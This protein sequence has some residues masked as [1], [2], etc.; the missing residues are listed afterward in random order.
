MKG[1]IFTPYEAT[2]TLPL[3]KNIVSDITN[4]AQRLRKLALT[5]P[6]T[7]ES[8]DEMSVLELELQEHMDELKNLGC[9]YKDW[10]FEIGLVDF[11]GIID[12]QLVLLCWRSDEPALE[13][14]HLPQAG[15]SG[16]KRIPKEL[17]EKPK[18]P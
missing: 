6:R 11:P 10:S 8:E 13:W 17:L 12:G 5:K 7:V 18:D 16:R 4:K 2:Q 9:S 15:F 14:Y 1:K 3:V